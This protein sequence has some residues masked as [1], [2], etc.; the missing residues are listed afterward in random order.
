MKSAKNAVIIVGIFI[1]VSAAALLIFSYR[2][3]KNTIQPTTTMK[4]TSPAFTHNQ[5][6]PR[7]FTCDGSDINPPLQISDVPAGAKSL[8]LIVDDPDAPRGDFV[9]WTLWNIAPDTKEIPENSVPANAIQGATDFGRHG[10]GG[11]C[12]PSGTHRYQ[13]KLYALDAMLDLPATAKK[14]DIERAMQGHIIEQTILVGLYQ[15][16]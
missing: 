8:A 4:L 13:F 9:H 5:N 11:P 14:Q 1:F 12:P 7:E 6:V 2:D 16:P 10:Y 3:L 15:R